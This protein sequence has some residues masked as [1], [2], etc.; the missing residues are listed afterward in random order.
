MKQPPSW[1]TGARLH[2]VSPGPYVTLVAAR[3]MSRT[4]LYVYQP[5]QTRDRECSSSTFSCTCSRRA[6]WAEN[7]LC[8]F[9]LSKCFSGYGPSSV[10]VSEH[11][12]KQY[13]S[14]ASESGWVHDLPVKLPPSVACW[15]RSEVPV[16][17]PRSLTHVGPEAT[18]ALARQAPSRPPTLPEDSGLRVLKTVLSRSVSAAGSRV[19]PSLPPFRV[20]CAPGP[21]LSPSQG[22]FPPALSQ[23]FP[24]KSSGGTP[25]WCP[26]PR[27]PRPTGAAPGGLR[28]Q[29]GGRGV[30]RPRRPHS[31]C[32]M[33]HGWCWEDLEAPLLK[34]S[35]VRMGRSSGGGEPGEV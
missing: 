32:R 11:P 28:G 6:V 2:T 35:P 10:T 19:R 16:A 18:E 34:A 8:D 13:S 22:A 25:S 24:R 17:A 29:G 20:R 3:R 21:T 7:V 23:T 14:E 12:A 33:G 27:R 4:A 5:Q 15:L 30:W 31:G 1:V 9:S 26:I